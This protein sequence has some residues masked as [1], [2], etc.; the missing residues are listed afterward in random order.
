CLP[1]FSGA[2]CNQASKWQ[3]QILIPTCMLK[4]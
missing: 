1:G 4:G 3:K 2:L